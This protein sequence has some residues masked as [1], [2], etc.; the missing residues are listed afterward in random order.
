MRRPQPKG[1]SRP[2]SNR[3]ELL[4]ALKDFEQQRTRQRARDRRQQRLARLFGW[5]RAVPGWARAAVVVTAVVLAALVADG[6]R[7]E[8]S[9]MTA[10]LAE[11]RGPVTIARG[12]Q[13][14]IPGRAGFL[15]RDRDVVTTGPGSFAVLV[16][17]DGSALELEPGTQFEVR[18]L[19]YQRGGQRD[20]S[21]MVRFGS[22]V[23][24]VSRF[25]GGRSQATVCTPTAVA[26]VRGTGFRVV[27]D[28]RQRQSYCQ[29][30][31]GTVQ[32]RT[33]AV[34][35]PTRAGQMVQAVGYR[36]GGVEA[37]PGTRGAS[38]RA[39]MARLARYERPPGLLERVEA[40]INGVLDPVLQLVGL[41]PGSWSYAA[42]TFARKAMCTESLRQLRAHLAAAPGEEVPDLLNP[43]TL[44]ELQMPLKERDKVLNG[45]AGRML[46]SY[47]K[48]GRDRYVVRA[49]ARNRA[50]T[51]F[52][53]TPEEIREVRE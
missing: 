9:E 19:D 20:R 11:V 50:R 35:A 45:F 37:L 30:A 7:R 5:V 47:R 46:E 41:A 25:F 8:A 14:E 42:S 27:Y 3:E 38:L 1:S 26:A 28:P 23:A 49:R 31:E 52:E 17:P 13:P 33:P 10:T 36:M 43:V 16:F 4:E 24:R 12:E 44:E 29:V 39:A 51:L 34:A 15:L 48:L 32:G 53:L 18:L 2:K 21:F 6:I 40:A 22:A